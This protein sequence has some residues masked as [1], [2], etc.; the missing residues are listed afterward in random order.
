MHRFFIEIVARL[1]EIDGIED[2][3]VEVPGRQLGKI[4][5]LRYGVLPFGLL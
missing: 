1:K 3:K 2:V 4:T 5:R